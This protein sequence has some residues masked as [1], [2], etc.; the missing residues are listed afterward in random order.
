MKDARHNQMADETNDS[1]ACCRRLKNKNE[2]QEI[3]SE[4]KKKNNIQSRCQ[5]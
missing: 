1:C 4:K 3:T 5:S 2:K